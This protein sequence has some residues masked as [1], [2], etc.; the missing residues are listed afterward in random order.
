RK[1]PAHR[2][3]AR[4][5]HERLGRRSARALV[6]DALQQVAVRDPGAREE[7]V[8]AAAET[9]LVEY[10]VEV[11]ALVDRGLALLLVS[12]PEATDD[13]AAHRLDAGRR[14]HALGR[15]AD[16]VQQVDGR[17]LRR[18]QKRAGHVAMQ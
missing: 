11:V 16:P 7:D 9:V 17:A 3:R 13:A 10:L 8:V 15:S 12:R 2:P 14:Q 18:C 4:A 1:D 6:A 5:S